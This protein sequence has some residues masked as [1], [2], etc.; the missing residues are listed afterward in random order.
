MTPSKCQYLPCACE[1][2]RQAARFL[3]RLRRCRSLAKK[4][5]GKNV[6]RRGE[7]VR[8]TAQRAS[9]QRAQGLSL[10][11]SA[12]CL[13]AV[14][15]CYLLYSFLS[16]SFT[17]AASVPAPPPS[18]PSHPFSKALS[19]RQGGTQRLVKTLFAISYYNGRGVGG[20]GSQ[21]FFWGVGE[22]QK[23][24]SAFL[25]LTSKVSS[26]SHVTAGRR[27][28]GERRGTDASA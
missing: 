3:R 8:F 11:S 14:G 20:G 23:E 26:G 5:Q 24:R 17:S 10:C 7:A 4:R 12:I 16:R 9:R 21:V 25:P 6:K 2:Q 18:P 19:H 15:P 13:S 28:R 27:P 22:R 1:T